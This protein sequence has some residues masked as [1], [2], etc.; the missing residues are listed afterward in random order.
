MGFVQKISVLAKY[1]NFKFLLLG[2]FYV[3][4]R[5]SA[6]TGSRYSLPFR[7]LARLK[8][9]STLKNFLILDVIILVIEVVAYCSFIDS[10]ACDVTSD[11]LAC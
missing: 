2:Y 6:T 9:H 8:V 1:V 3:D 5:A 10:L 4:D 11:G 7:D